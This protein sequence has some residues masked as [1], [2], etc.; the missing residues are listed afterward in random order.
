MIKRMV[1]L[2]RWCSGAH[3][4]T[5]PQL[6][7]QLRPPLGFRMRRTPLSGLRARPSH[8]RRANKSARGGFN[9]RALHS[10]PGIRISVISA[11]AC[12]CA[13]GCKCE[14]TSIAADI[15]PSQARAGTPRPPRGEHTQG[16]P[17]MPVRVAPRACCCAVLGCIACAPVP[18]CADP[19]RMPG[20][21][22][23]RSS[24]AQVRFCWRIGSAAAP[25]AQPRGVLRK[26]QRRPGQLRLQ[27][28]IGHCAPPHHRNK[29]TIHLNMMALSSLAYI[30]AIMKAFMF[31]IRRTT[32]SWLSGTE[33]LNCSVILFCSSPSCIRFTKQKTTIQSRVSLDTI[34]ALTR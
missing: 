22:R 20:R 17:G 31:H 8:C 11:F 29:P 13:R 4:Y 14:F 7:W 33:L 12:A 27:G 2:F 15:N 18:T 24:R 30:R 32:I 34:H 10:R 21:A 1:G 9:S 26:T 28:G 6:R 5:Q 16:S 3:M 25:R 19:D 23:V